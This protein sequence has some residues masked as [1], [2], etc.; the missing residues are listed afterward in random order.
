MQYRFERRAELQAWSEPPKEWEDRRGAP[1]RL[2][3]SQFQQLDKT[4]ALSLCMGYK[5]LD[6][7]VILC[8][9]LRPMYKCHLTEATQGHWESQTCGAT[10]STQKPAL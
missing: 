3:A 4:T 10:V 2:R 7:I 8:E 6:R 1:A 5:I 9:A